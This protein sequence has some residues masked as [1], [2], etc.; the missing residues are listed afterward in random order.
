[1]KLVSYDAG[2]TLKPGILIDGD[3]HDIADLLPDAPTSV[4]ELIEAHGDDLPGLARSLEAAAASRG[5]PVGDVKLG[6]P[7]PDPAKVLCVGINYRDHAAETGRKLP[8]H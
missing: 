6:P 8:Q 7:V 3:V 1:M 2:G 4:R 5:A